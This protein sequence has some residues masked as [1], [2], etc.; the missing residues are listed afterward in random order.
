VL[1]LV[2]HFH[3]DRLPSPFMGPGVADGQRQV[4]V[5]QRR[6]P[7]ILE[8]VG[9]EVGVVGPFPDRVTEVETCCALL[10]TDC[11]LLAAG[12]TARA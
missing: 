2:E 4:G 12:S 10:P 1:G 3:D 8:L 6:I 7:R 5:E 11:S 9:I